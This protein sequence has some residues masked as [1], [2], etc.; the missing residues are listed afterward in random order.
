MSAGEQSMGLGL[1]WLNRFASLDLI[2]RIGLRVPAQRLVY[3][4][5]KSGFKAASSA[6]R[7]FAAAQKLASPQRLPKV[8]GDGDVRPHPRRRAADAPRGV[9]RLRR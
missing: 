5:T 4:A 2:D 1:R 8:K 9:R 7:T 6:G 3:G